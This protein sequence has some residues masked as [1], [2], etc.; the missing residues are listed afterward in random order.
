MVREATVDS[1]TLA[2]LLRPRHAQVVEQEVEPGR[3]E[4]ST[5]PFR[6]YLRTVEV[7]ER[8][9]G[10]AVVRQTVEFELAIPFWG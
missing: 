5:G 8:R 10:D 9:S 3:F 6:E 7:I 1:D 4:A 2:E